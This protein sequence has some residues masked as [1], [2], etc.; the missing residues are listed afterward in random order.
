MNMEDE[1]K[2][3]KRLVLS[4]LLFYQMSMYVYVYPVLDTVAMDETKEFSL[5]SFFFSYHFIAFLYKS[6]LNAK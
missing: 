2:F 3:L 4:P 1:A 6:T 5:F